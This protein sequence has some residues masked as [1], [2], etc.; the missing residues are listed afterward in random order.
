MRQFLAAACAVIL[1]LSAAPSA[2]AQ[3]SSTGWLEHG[4]YQAY[5]DARAYGGLVPVHV[6]AGLYYGHL[7]YQAIFGPQPY[8]VSTW[9]THHGMSDALFAQTNQNYLNQG[10]RLAQHQRFDTEGHLVNQ[11]IWYR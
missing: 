5:F 8:G 3:Q 11:G 7:R 1:L 2:N 4:Q 6:E 10:Y 9:A